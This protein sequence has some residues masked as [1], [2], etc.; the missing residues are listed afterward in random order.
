M[1]DDGN[2]QQRLGMMSVQKT[3]GGI[4]TAMRWDIPYA[5]LH[6]AIEEGY[7]S[8]LENALL[9]WVKAWKIE[10]SKRYYLQLQL[11]DASSTM[12]A[13][14]R[15]F[16]MITARLRSCGSPTPTLA[17]EYSDLIDANRRCRAQWKEW[18]RKYAELA[19]RDVFYRPALHAYGVSY[20]AGAPGE[21][22]PGAP[23]ADGD[24]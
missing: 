18:Q 11:L 17:S 3:S 20:L 19:K 2:E 8:R 22:D 7:R 14:E 16:K 5:A 13:L 1:V 4:D 10:E 24:S 12:N 15:D 21:R 23:P 6:V 9:P